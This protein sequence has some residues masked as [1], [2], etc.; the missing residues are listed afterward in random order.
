MNRAQICRWHEFDS[1]FDFERAAGKFILQTSEQAIA[2]NGAFRI[3]LAGGSTPRNIY[4]QLCNADTDW[5]AWHI[6]FGD[7]R[8]LPANDSERN[9]RMARA[10]LLDRVAIP[11][12]QIH[13]IPAELGPEIAALR[14]AR[15][16]AGVGDF[17][18]VLLGLGEDGHTASLFPGGAWERAAT[19]P[20]VIPVYDAPKPPP[21]RVSL[22]PERLSRARRV[23]YLVCGEGKRGAIGNWRAGVALPASRICP[24]AG[25]DVFL[26]F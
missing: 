12:R 25:V 7:E 22:S 8:C 9:S 11:S 16:L 10:A 23:I 13:P 24:A 26:N 18:L 15:E 19:L 20:P 21:Q 6:Y 14:Y 17:D 1:R 3:V 2:A 4:R 5:A